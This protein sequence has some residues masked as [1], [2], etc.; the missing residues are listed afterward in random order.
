MAEEMSV[1]PVHE[2][3]RVTYGEA[4]DMLSR[5]RRR[6]EGP[7]ASATMTAAS[8]SGQT[9]FPLLDYVIGERMPD[10]L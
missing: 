1:W 5:I 8:A 9:S 7:R 3:V 10:Q 4:H 2:K 6:V